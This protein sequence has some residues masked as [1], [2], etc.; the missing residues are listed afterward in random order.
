[1]IAVLMRLKS[2]GCLAVRMLDC[3]PRGTRFKHRP[4]QK[5]SL[6]SAHSL[7]LFCPTKMNIGVSW[8]L[9]IRE[10]ILCWLTVV[11]D[12]TSTLVETIVPDVLDSNITHTGMPL[13]YIL[14]DCITSS[15]DIDI[16]AM[17]SRQLQSYALMLLST[18]WFKIA[19]GRATTQEKYTTYGT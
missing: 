15:S 8:G 13:H 3:Q 12:F 11:G 9:K 2:S 4:W 19:P 17:K 14:F 7:D 10:G 16:M 5:I 1:M 18:T 6:L